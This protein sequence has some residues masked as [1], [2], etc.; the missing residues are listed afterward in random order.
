MR[1]LVA[2]LSLL[3]A[4]ASFAQELAGRILV[5]AGDVA[6]V[7]AGQ[8]VTAGPGAEVRTGD[9]IF[10]GENSVAQVRLT[11]ESLISFQPRTT[12]EVTEY[13]FQGLAADRQRAVFRLI[14]GGMR[15]ITGLIGRVHQA[16]YRVATPTSTIGIRGT[17]YT[18][19]HRDEFVLRD[20][21]KLPGGTYGAV[22]DGRIAVTNQVGETVFGAD[23]YFRVASPTTQPQQLL[24][25]PTEILSVKTERRQT[26]QQQQQQATSSGGESV[27]TVAQTGASA[28]TGDTRVSSS[29]SNT[30][31]PLN[32]STTLYQPTTDVSIGGPAT[33]LQPTLTGTVFY[34]LQGPFS[35][36]VSCS[37]PPCGTIV[38]G[39]ITL[40]INLALQLAGVTASL[41]IDDGTKIDL[42]TP[43]AAGG[44]PVSISNGQ[45]TFSATANR[46]DFPQNQFAFR[47]STCGPGDTPGFVDGI[48]ISGTVSGSQANLTLGA[49]DMD[50]THSFTAT[51]TSATPPNNA[52]AAVALPGFSGGYSA[53]SAALWGVDVASTGALLRINGGGQ[54]MIGLVGTATSTIKGSDA[55]AGNLVWGQWSGPGTATVTDQNYTTFST[56][57]FIPWI[58]GTAINTLPT[59]LGTVSFTPIG[60][61]VNGGPPNGLLNSASLTADFVNRSLSVSLNA[62][63]VSF[64]NTFQMNGTT[65]FSPIT[66]R[67]SAGFQSVSCTGSNCTGT[68]GGSYAGFF[69]GPDAPGAGLTFS[70][71][72]AA[73][74]GVTGVVAFKR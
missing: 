50:G 38:N 31:I 68:P 67:F 4:S 49:I 23:Q 43:S 26:A 37:I 16:G 21:G 3:A 42:S 19:A 10:V 64:N 39:Q 17:H 74:N 45:I 6:I 7:R 57:A 35:L 46:V 63:N 65:G 1:L 53:R 40:G 44:F 59:S 55:A 66:G 9:T 62:T 27:P 36:P 73:G 58:T 30:A 29:V 51:L 24:R 48:S 41:L 32:L 52:V 13:A 20:G 15:T 33:V 8:R 56:S 2:L 22:T 71:G 14:V 54:N 28:G 70:A 25:P 69:T 72:F 60:S 61:L 5:A 34:R 11:D 12:F 18:L 47:C